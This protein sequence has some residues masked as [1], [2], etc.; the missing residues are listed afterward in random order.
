MSLAAI[1][2]F[3][4]PL[5]R[6]I[7][8]GKCVTHDYTR[9]FPGHDYVFRPQLRGQRGHMMGWGRGIKQDDFLL[10]ENGST[11]TRYRVIAIEYFTDPSD[12][13]SANV[14]FAPREAGP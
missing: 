13:W 8:T 1:A 5:H 2:R 9:R 7:Q 11:S 10:L 6:R 4:E 14:Q 12:M 3:M